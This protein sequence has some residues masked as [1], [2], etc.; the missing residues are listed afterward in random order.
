MAFLPL[1]D[2]VL[3]SWAQQTPCQNWDGA[4]LH[5]ASLEIRGHKDAPLATPEAA[6]V[7]LSVFPVFKLCEVQRVLRLNGIPLKSV[8]RLTK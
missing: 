6:N 5:L 4:A 7:Q 2:P 3:Q 8:L 1:Q